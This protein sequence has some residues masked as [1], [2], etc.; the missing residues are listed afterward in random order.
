MISMVV[1][2]LVLAAVTVFYMGSAQSV[3]FQA[4]V[5][6][7][8]ENGRFAIDILSR[9]MRMAGYDDPFN[10]FVVEQPLI[11]GTTVSSGALITLP[12]MKENG[13][14][15]AVRFEGG[16]KI[17]DCLGAPVAAGTFV[18]N[19]YGIST[20]NNLVCGTSTTNSTPI[21][22]GVEDMQVLYGI[23]FDGDNFANRYVAADNVSD[24]NQVV[25]IQ[26]AIL[27]NSIS[28]VLTSA[29]TVCLGCTVFSGTAD[30]KIRA[31]FQT[32]IGVRN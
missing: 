30:H 14:T 21:A 32:V 6:K 10:T 5:Q 12:D 31:E 23:D 4:S 3:R 7:V 20:E 27:V 13:D 11:K 19:L 24:W 16:T 26:I 22:E 2:L 25:T 17:R 18:T 29:D 28:N 1:G 9:T 15:V 8:Q